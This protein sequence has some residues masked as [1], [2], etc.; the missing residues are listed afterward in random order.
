MMKRLLIVLMAAC[1]FACQDDYSTLGDSLVV[2]SFRNVYTDTCTVKMSTIFVDSMET[3]GQSVCQIGYIDD[4][5]WGEVLSAYIAE[6]SKASFTPG[7][8]YTYSLDSLVLTLKPSGNYWGDTLTAQRIGVYPLVSA[9]TLVNDETLYSHTKTP[10]TAEPLFSFMYTPR[11]LQNKSVTVRMPDTFGQELLDLLVAESEVFESQ[12]KFKAYLHGLAFIPDRSGNCVT[13]FAVADSSMVMTLHYHESG[14]WREERTLSFTV[15]TEYAYNY[16]DYNRHTALGTIEGGRVNSVTASK[17]GKQAFLQG[18]GAYYNVIE[19]PYLNDLQVD[20][21]IVSIQSAVL[22]LY[23]KLGSYG[24]V[25]QLPETL[26]LYLANENNMAED[27]VYDSSGSTVQNGNL[28]IDETS[29]RETYYSF[30]LTSYMQSNLGTWG[31]KR[32]NLLLSMEDTDFQQTFSQVIF[33][34]DASQ[35][36]GYVRLDVRY[37]TYNKE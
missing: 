27:N 1:L 34:C 21:D 13:G 22:Y 30:D 19:F 20:G 16:V 9:I 37:K 32:Q 4:P 33:D 2:S 5:V 26:R 25:N 7:E 31:M 17:L 10:V 18:M 3:R 24:A 28:T 23:P 6:F 12:E 8:G 14:S 15:N 36:R 29:K 35:E 11:P